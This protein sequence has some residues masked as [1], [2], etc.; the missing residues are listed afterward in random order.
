MYSC[1]VARSW[2]EVKDDW[3]EDI[4]RNNPVVSTGL[5]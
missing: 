1:L 5:G 3:C 2:F 4:G